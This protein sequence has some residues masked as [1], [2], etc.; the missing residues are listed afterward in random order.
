MSNKT[1]PANEYK[2]S[3]HN[4]TDSA[5]CVIDLLSILQHINISN[6]KQYIHEQI[7]NSSFDKSIQSTCFYEL[8]VD[9]H[10]NKNRT[11]SKEWNQHFIKNEE[12]YFRNKYQSDNV[13]K[14][15][16]DALDKDIKRLQHKMN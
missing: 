11:V 3:L 1:K 2:K 15:D 8:L 5:K 14:I 4:Y 6:T 12:M 9:Q 13:Y 7:D 16:N 10:S